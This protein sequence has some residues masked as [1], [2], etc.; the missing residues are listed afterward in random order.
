MIYQLILRIHCRACHFD[1]SKGRGDLRYPLRGIEEKGI[2]LLQWI[3]YVL[4]ITACFV[5]VL[6]CLISVGQKVEE[7]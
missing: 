4:N 3:Y 2:W 7:S 6:L 1:R 5:L